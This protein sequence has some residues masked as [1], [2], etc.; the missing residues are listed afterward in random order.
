M[1]GFSHREV[2]IINFLPSNKV[3]P[4]DNMGAAAPTVALDKENFLP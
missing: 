3:E 4:S 2:K 1:N